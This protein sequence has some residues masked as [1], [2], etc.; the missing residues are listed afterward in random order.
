MY[1]GCYA[2]LQPFRGWQRESSEYIYYDHCLLDTIYIV[3]GKSIQTSKW[4]YN[5]CLSNLTY[6]AE[7]VEIVKN[8]DISMQVTSYIALSPYQ[9]YHLT[10]YLVCPGFTNLQGSNSILHGL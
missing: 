9:S 10:T 7:R 3:E 1:V 8:L 6:L 4:I 2:F 5:Q